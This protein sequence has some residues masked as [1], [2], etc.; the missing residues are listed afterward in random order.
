MIIL[1]PL[2]LL[3]EHVTILHVE[4]PTPLELY[5]TLRFW[6]FLLSGLS[7]ARVQF[8]RLF[9]LFSQLGGETRFNFIDL[10]AWW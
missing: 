8:L 9:F 6:V 4:T 5:V 3:R 10:H 2:P 7:L 1:R